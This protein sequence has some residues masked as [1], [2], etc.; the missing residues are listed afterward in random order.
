MNQ[1][2]GFAHYI[3]EHQ[4]DLIQ[5]FLDYLFYKFSNN[6]AYPLIL[7]KVKKKSY[8]WWRPR[9]VGLYTFLFYINMWKWNCNFDDNFWD[10]IWY[11]S[12]HLATWFKNIS[13]VGSFVFNSLC[14]FLYVLKWSI[15][16]NVLKIN[17]KIIKTKQIKIILW[18][19][20]MIHAKAVCSLVFYWHL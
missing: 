16:R 5:A 4:K 20:G 3:L 15:F 17:V 6:G 19:L 13:L 11:F 1:K 9:F 14:N 2:E 18:V 7:L 12:F 10:D 8:G